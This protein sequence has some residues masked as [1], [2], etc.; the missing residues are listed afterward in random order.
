MSDSRVTV[1]PWAV[2][3]FLTVQLAPEDFLRFV[4]YNVMTIN[5]LTKK[6]KHKDHNLFIK[7]VAKIDNHKCKLE[8]FNIRVSYKSS[9]RSPKLSWSLLSLVFRHLYVLFISPEEKEKFKDQI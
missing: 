6:I 8:G 4:M 1:S 7:N 3:L 2:N 9:R 5:S